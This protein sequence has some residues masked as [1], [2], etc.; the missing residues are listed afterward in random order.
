MQQN[1]KA[2]IR[3]TNKTVKKSWDKECLAFS[4]SDIILS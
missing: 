4:K 2:S 3:K 1:E